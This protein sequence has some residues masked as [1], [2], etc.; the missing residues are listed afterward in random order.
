M[1]RSQERDALHGPWPTR[2]EE[3][4]A[5]YANR[6]IIYREL[7]EDGT[8]GNWVADPHHPDEDERLTARVIEHLAE[9]LQHAA[10][11]WSP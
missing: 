6:Y 9:Q 8:H 10:E 1:D 5:Q 11:S 7:H 2:S 4:A 3:L